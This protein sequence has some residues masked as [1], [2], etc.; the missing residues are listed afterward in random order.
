MPALAAVLVGLFIFFST[1]IGAYEVSGGLF[2]EGLYM[3]CVA[4]ALAAVGA[5]A[6]DTTSRSVTVARPKKRRRMLDLARQPD[7]LPRAYL[8]MYT[9]PFLPIALLTFGAGILV[10]V[11]L[12]GIA[13]MVDQI[14]AA[15]VYISSSTV[16]EIVMAGGLVLMS[17]A[18]AAWRSRPAAFGC[19]VGIAL[20]TLAA[21]YALSNTL[22]SLPWKIFGI[23]LVILTGLILIVGALFR[24]RGARRQA[25]LTPAV[26][27]PTRS[28]PPTQ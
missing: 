1:L 24:R 28:L 23:G 12:H 14:L 5:M 26:S 17:L 8:Q 3:F 18:L 6:V 15:P 27:A 16:P 22:E 7:R 2:V 4:A 25:G 9:I 21:K 13:D 11:M 10:S 19:V 20:A